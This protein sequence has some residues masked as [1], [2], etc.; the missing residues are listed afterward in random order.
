MII[1][2]LM[3]LFMRWRCRL[4]K[5]LTCFHFNPDPNQTKRACIEY[6]HRRVE[7][8]VLRDC[9]GTAPWFIDMQLSTHLGLSATWWTQ[10]STIWHIIIRSGSKV[11]IGQERNLLAHKSSLCVQWRYCDMAYEEVLSLISAWGVHCLRV[12]MSISPTK[13]R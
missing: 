5:I 11:S 10:S 7:D 1:P 8:S 4:I 3:V 9:P 2:S 12:L 13:W 6:D